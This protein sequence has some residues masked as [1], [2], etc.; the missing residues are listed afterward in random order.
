MNRNVFILMISVSIACWGCGKSA[1]KDK[2][3]EP[4]AGGT[5]PSTQVETTP[6]G[7]D[8][9]GGGI[10]DTV[11][12]TV[13]ELV[14]S[15]KFVGKVV[16]VEGRCAGWSSDLAAGGPPVTRSDWVLE[17]GKEG[18][19]VTGPLPAGCSSTGG[20]E[21]T[22]SI[23]ARVAEDSVRVLGEDGGGKTRRYLVLIPE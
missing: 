19:Y 22:I 20:S 8:G 13:A 5:T 1:H 3:G 4:P 7:N 16:T 23:V 6:G 14:T 18:I 12:A 2:P 17:D 21:E 15:E 11:A 10:S 9:G